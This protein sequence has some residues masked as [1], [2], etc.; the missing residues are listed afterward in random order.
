MR[1]ALSMLLLIAA[2][3]AV[4]LAARRPPLN[5]RGSDPLAI[6]PVRVPAAPAQGGS[7]GSQDAP[8]R[9]GIPFCSD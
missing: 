5:A 3:G 7:R 4:V 2:V 6:E 1:P 8:P 9:P